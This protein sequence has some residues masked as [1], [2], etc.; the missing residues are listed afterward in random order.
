MAAASV[1]EDKRFG[2][3][4]KELPKL[5]GR[6]PY[7]DLLDGL[8]MRSSKLPSINKLDLHR[9]DLD[10]D[11]LADVKMVHEFINTFGSPLGL[12]KD[13]GEWITYGKQLPTS[14]H[15]YGIV[16]DLTSLQFVMRNQSHTLHFSLHRCS[17]WNDQESSCGQSTFGSQLQNDYCCL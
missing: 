7:E 17:A 15:S 11:M 3:L 9:Q 4:L 10:M 12:T 2:S 8:I 5:T 14:H 16:C 1:D 13:C 6:A